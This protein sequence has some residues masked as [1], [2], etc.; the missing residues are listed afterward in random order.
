MLLEPMEKA[1]EE[2]TYR[3]IRELYGPEIASQLLYAYGDLTTCC[4]QV[5]MSSKGCLKSSPAV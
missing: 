5:A 3:I 1:V 4:D 2:E